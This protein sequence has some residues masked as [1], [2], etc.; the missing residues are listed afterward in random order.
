[1][2]EQK[3]VTPQPRYAVMRRPML[4]FAGLAFVA[5]IAPVHSPGWTYDLRVQGVV[6]DDVAVMV[7]VSSFGLNNITITGHFVSSKYPVGCLSV[8]KD[9]RYELRDINN[10][11]IPVS[12]QALEQPQM[13]VPRMEHMIAG[14]H[15]PHPCSANAPMGVWD[16]TAWLDVLYP[17]L[18]PGPYTLRVSFAP[19]G[20][21][22]HFD[23]APVAI[24]I[25][26]RP[27]P[28]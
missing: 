7:T 20:W 3:S 2:T 24:T 16:A 17:N 11:I 18:L 1:M 12:E 26:P 15:H 13:E 5:T 6:V 25:R 4:I 10:R 14:G 9:L 21:A 28:T 22:Q 23:F 19:R 27:K 8:Y